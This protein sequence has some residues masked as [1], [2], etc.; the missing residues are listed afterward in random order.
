VKVRLIVAATKDAQL[1]AEQF[2][3]NSGVT[4]GPLGRAGA[5]RAPAGRRVAGRG[6][7][8]ASIPQPTTRRGCA[9]ARGEPVPTSWCRS[10]SAP[11]S[12][13]RSSQLETWSAASSPGR[14]PVRN[15]IAWTA[16]LSDLK[17][18]RLVL[19]VGFV[20]VDELPGDRRPTWR[21]GVWERCGGRASVGFNAFPSRFEARGGRSRGGCSPARFSCPPGGGAMTR[22]SGHRRYHPDRRR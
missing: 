7:S 13:R 14:H 2:A 16:R 12:A 5:D 1:R 6:P 17:D 21:G 22:L 10:S 19:G 11:P 3:A 15:S 18:D 9:P 4:V 20:P 8:G